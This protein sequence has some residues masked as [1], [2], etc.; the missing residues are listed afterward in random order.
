MTQSNYTAMKLPVP[1]LG[2]QLEIVEHL[3]RENESIDVLIS[4]K[5]ALIL[6][7]EQ[8]KKSLIFEIVTGKRRVC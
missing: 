1:M 2:E 6:D 7:L 5:E 8:Y 4:E 3:D